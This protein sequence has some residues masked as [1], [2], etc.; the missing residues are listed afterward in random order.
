[1][2][3]APSPANA[4]CLLF[5]TYFENV[6]LRQREPCLRGERNEGPA[7]LVAISL[8][9][10]RSRGQHLC[11]HWRLR[12]KRFRKGSFIDSC[13]SNVPDAASASVCYPERGRVELARQTARVEGPCVRRR[14]RTLFCEDITCAWKRYLCLETLFQINVYD[15]EADFTLRRPHLNGCSSRR[16]KRALQAR[17]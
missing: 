3:R 6:I 7:V 14:C 12:L 16:N 5:P 15:L 4:A 17:Q 11:G 2:A 10:V 8:W 1:V 13:V 9:R